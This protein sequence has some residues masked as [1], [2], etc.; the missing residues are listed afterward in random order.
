MGPSRPAVARTPTAASAPPKLGTRERSWTGTQ[1]A[2][3]DFRAVLNT[4][5]SK[6]PGKVTPLAQVYVFQDPEG[7]LRFKI[8]SGD[9]LTRLKD[10]R[11]HCDDNLQ[12]V[13]VSAHLPRNFARRVETLTHSELLHF[14]ESPSPCKL[15]KHRNVILHKEYFSGVKLD[16][17]G[18]IIERWSFLIMLEPYENGEF[19]NDMEEGMIQFMTKEKRPTKEDKDHQRRHD[20][21]WEA[22]HT[23]LCCRAAGWDKKTLAEVKKAVE[24]D[25]EERRENMEEMMKNL[26][27][28][29]KDDESEYDTEYDGEDEVATPSPSPP[30]KMLSSH[31]AYA[32]ADGIREMPERRFTTHLPGIAY[33]HL[34]VMF[35]MVSA[36]SLIHCPKWTIS[37]YIS[38]IIWLAFNDLEAFIL[39]LRWMEITGSELLRIAGNATRILGDGFWVSGQKLAEQFT[40]V[41]ARNGIVSQAG[42]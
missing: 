2:A 31:P 39:I 34:Y 15:R 13:Y 12:P 17:I 19:R 18:Q 24:E 9:T 5:K 40:T 33:E 27:S 42:K 23:K 28:K 16:V 3:D 8:G 36:A 10:L 7:T 26:G 25:S 6:L 41:A 14:R 32:R 22:I 29:E 11:E 30:K 4:M 38:Y 20:W 37:I 35:L 1:T 21:W